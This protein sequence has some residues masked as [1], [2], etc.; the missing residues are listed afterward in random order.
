MGGETV[1]AMLKGGGGW[2]G[3]WGGGHKAF[4]PDLREGG[5]GFGPATVPVCSPPQ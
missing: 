4:Y 3:G 5:G 2:V 1:L